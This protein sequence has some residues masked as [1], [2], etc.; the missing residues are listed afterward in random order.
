MK[1]LKFSVLA[2]FLMV[3][4][5]SLGSCTDDDNGASAP[6]PAFEQEL[7]KL[8][9]NATSIDW[10]Q[11]G[12]Y[13]VADCRADGR[14]RRVWLDAGANW[15]MT[16][17][18]LNSTNDLLPAVYTAFQNSTYSNWVVEDVTLL[19]YPNEPSPEFVIDV[20]QG[21]R[22]VALYFS[23]FGGLL[24]EKDVTKDDTH[25]PRI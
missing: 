17:T 3:A 16:E 19:E 1:Y 15:V 10:E 13:Y 9:P 4:I 20:E 14:E 6:S 5:L 11:K 23:E 21:N 25:W 24:H 7:R 2:T 12:A 22:E 18:E 8:F